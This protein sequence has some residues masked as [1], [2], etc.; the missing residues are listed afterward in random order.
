MY[1]LAKA[2]QLAGV[3]SIIASLWKVPDEKTAQLFNIFYGA[4]STGSD[5]VEALR[6][7]QLSLAQS[8]HPVADWGAFVHY[9]PGFALN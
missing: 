6:L 1:G 3:A 7:A 8:G 5:S 4:L 9:G 2:F